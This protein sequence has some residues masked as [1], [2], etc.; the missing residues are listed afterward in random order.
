MSFSRCCFVDGTNAG[1]ETLKVLLTVDM[2]VELLRVTR[3]GGG[4]CF[5]VDND[6]DDDTEDVE[7]S[8]GSG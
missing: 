2:G 5:C 4:G 8:N 1:D 7:I 6:M 3:R